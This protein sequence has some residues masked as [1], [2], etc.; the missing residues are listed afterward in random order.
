VLLAQGRSVRW[1]WGLAP[2]LIPVYLFDITRGETKKDSRIGVETFG[3]GFKRLGLINLQS[4][5]QGACFQIFKV[6]RAGCRLSDEPEYVL[7]VDTSNKS[8]YLLYG[9]LGNE[10]QAKQ[11]CYELTKREKE[12]KIAELSEQR[13]AHELFP[14]L[15]GGELELVIENEP[16]SS[17]KSFH[18]RIKS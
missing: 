2:G 8:A 14:Q 6:W 9:L 3:Y 4:E 1:V 16:S 7:H 17:E 18:F 11:H 13:R 15:C 5:S 12:E 10:E